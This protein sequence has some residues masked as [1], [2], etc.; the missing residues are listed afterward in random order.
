MS[1]L[2]LSGL[3]LVEVVIAL[4][5]LSPISVTE[6]R[7]LKTI[8]I[9][10]Q[11]GGKTYQATKAKEDKKKSKANKTAI[12]FNYDTENTPAA[13]AEPGMITNFFWLTQASLPNSRITNSLA[14]KIR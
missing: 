6:E 12:G 4:K 1:K 9:E 8:E 11:F 3:L 5:S 2:I 7:F 10:E 14:L 13:T